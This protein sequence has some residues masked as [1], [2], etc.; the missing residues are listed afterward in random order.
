M[1]V[2]RQLRVSAQRD[3]RRESDTVHAHHDTGSAHGYDGVVPAH[4]GL[5][6]LP[7]IAHFPCIYACSSCML[8]V[9]KL[10]ISDFNQLQY[11]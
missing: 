5:Q 11:G 9:A 10:A 2:N 7:Q 3:E 1:A 6:H 4:R 8:L